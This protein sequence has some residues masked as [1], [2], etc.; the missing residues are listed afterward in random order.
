[1]VCNKKTRFRAPYSSHVS[2]NKTA[3]RLKSLKTPIRSILLFRSYVNECILQSTPVQTLHIVRPEQMH[4]ELLYQYIENQ[5]PNW[6]TILIFRT[7]LLLIFQTP[8]CGYVLV[9]G[10]EV[11]TTTLTL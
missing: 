5:L 9:A 3:Q 8:G 2:G 1:M 6:P 11:L 4:E 7:V 10:L